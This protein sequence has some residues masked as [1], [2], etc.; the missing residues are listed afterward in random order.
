MF[1][2]CCYA[3]Y[4]AICFTRYYIRLSPLRFISPGLQLQLATWLVAALAASLL[5]HM[6]ALPPY[7]RVIYAR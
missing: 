5:P 6:K 1:F 2:R 7:A 3:V 4:A